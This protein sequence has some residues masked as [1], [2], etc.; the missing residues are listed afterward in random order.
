ML[1]HPRPGLAPP[2][3]A[4]E[5]GERHPQVAGREYA[6]LVAQPARGAAVVGDRDDGGQVGGDAA[7]GGQGGRQPVAATEGDDR[8]L[9]RPAHAGYSRPRSRWVT[10]ASSPAARS[11]LTIS[12]VIATLRCLPPVQPIATVMNRLPSRR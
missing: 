1:Q 4:A 9:R 8:R 11:R 3:V 10:S 7:Q 6:E 2:V 5:G 12:S